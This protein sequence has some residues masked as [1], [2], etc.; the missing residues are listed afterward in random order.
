MI[1]VLCLVLCLEGREERGY[2]Q[3]DSGSHD[4][5]FWLYIFYL[6]QEKRNERSVS[7]SVCVVSASATKMA[8]CRSR[9]YE[10]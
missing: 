1:D 6:V 8:G 9:R 4:R 3:S 5:A 10:L 7:V 2:T